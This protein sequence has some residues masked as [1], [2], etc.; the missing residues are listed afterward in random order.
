MSVTSAG[1]RATR[2]RGRFR[3]PDE[4]GLA[5]VLILATIVSVALVGDQPVGQ[6]VAAALSGGTLL[7]ILQTS[8][9]PRRTMRLATV[10]VVFALV[11]TTVGIFLQNGFV[12]GTAYGLMIGFIAVV[13]PVIIASRIVRHETITLRTVAGALCLYLLIGLFFATLYGLVAQVQSGFFVQTDQPTSTDFIY[14]SF[15]TMTTTGYGDFTAAQPLGRMLAVTEALFGQLYLVSAVA[16]LIGNIGRSR[17][18]GAP[19][20]AP[21]VFDEL[22]SM[23]DEPTEAPQA[24]D[25]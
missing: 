2:V 19:A 25:R 23:V 13:S 24:V 3:Q 14:F 21:D 16:L 18:S 15:I 9:A 17:S 11:G 5:L 4:Y 20:A 6:L 10:I 12:D 8:Q 7:F 22:E 1:V